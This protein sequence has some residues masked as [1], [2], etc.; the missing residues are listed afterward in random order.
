M[1]KPELLAPAGSYERARIAYLYGADA[2]Y[3]GTADLSLRTRVNIDNDDF[4][5]IVNLAKH[6]DKKVFAALNIYAF[7]ADYHKVKTQAKILNDMGVD[8]VILSDG[9]VLETVKEYAPNVDIHISTQANTVSLETSKFWYKNGAKRIILAREMS[10]DKI[11]Y[12]MENKPEDLEMEMFIHGAVCVGYSGRC[13]LSNYLTGRASNQGDCAQPCRWNYNV[14]I[15][16][17]NTPG[18]LMPV[19]ED[20]RGTYIL[21]AKDLCLIHRIPEIIEMGVESLKIEGRLKTEYYLATVVNAYRNAID[22]YIADKASWNAETY[23]TEL[24]K[25]MS[26][27][28]SELFYDREDNKEIQNYDDDGRSTVPYEYGAKV[29]EKTDDLS[30]LEV[31]NK[32]AVGDVMEMIVPNQTLPEVIPVTDLYDYETKER[33]DVVNPGKA[34]QKVLMRLP[35]VAENNFVIRRRKSV[36]SK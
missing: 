9:G 32:I 2:I 15:E 20:G 5:K 6:L 23:Q 36:S 11:K 25:A 33:I 28:Y 27:N 16:E 22:E 35:E 8:A 10:R 18:K 4:V 26:R 7:D 29:L 21:S 1:K 3:A 12:I 31:R 13:I 19:E 34:D 30:V 14:Y 17:K 24:D